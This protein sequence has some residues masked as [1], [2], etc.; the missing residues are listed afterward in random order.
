MEGLE[1]E[2]SSL[3]QML[4]TVIHNAKI[5]HIK[6]EVIVGALYTIAQIEK[7]KLSNA[8]PSE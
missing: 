7:E 5:N 3:C 8:N 4:K 2:F 6:Q 1:C